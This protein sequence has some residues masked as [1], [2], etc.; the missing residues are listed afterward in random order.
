MNWLFPEFLAGAFA[1]G[2]P[3]LLHLL[4]RWPRRPVVFPSLRFLNAGKRSSD[5]LW[6]RLCRWL[7]L[8]LR[9]LVL[10]LLAA[11]FARPFF[12][13]RDLTRPN[14]AVAI[15]VDNSFSL[16]SG[17]RW[18]DLRQWAR[19]KV[20][21]LAEGDKVGLMLMAPQP[22]WVI[23]PTVDTT[24]PLEALAGLSP[25]WLTARAEPA[26]R[27]A[28]DALAALP[29]D[30]REI[31]LV[32]DEQRLTWSGSDFGRKLPPGVTV[33]SS[34]IPPAPARQAAVLPPILTTTERGLRATVTVRN[35]TGRQTRTLSLYRNDPAIS[36]G[37]ATSRSR[38]GDQEVAAPFSPSAN[39]SPSPRPLRVEKLELEPQETRTVEI[40]LPGPTDHAFWLRCRLDADDLA[41]D[42]SA[43]AVWQPSSEGP[44]LLDAAAPGADADFAGVALASAA[45]LPPAFT[46]MAPPAGKW[47]ARA[48]AVLRND[49]SFSGAAAANLDAFLADGGSALIFASGGPA[50]SAW[51]AVHQVTFSPLPRRTESWPVHDWAMGHALVAALSQR[52]LQMLLGWEFTQGWSMPAQ[53]VEPL[54]HWSDDAAAIGEIRV[55]P[56]RVLACGFIPDRRAGDWPVTPSFLPF[57]HQA[58]TYLFHAQQVTAVTG[59]T[60]QT[61]PLEGPAGRWHG[62][63]GPAA[64]VTETELSGA[65]TPLL[66]G[67]YEFTQDKDRKLFAVN[68]PA[69]E[70]DLASWTA[71]T[72]WLGLISAEPAPEAKIPRVQIA[73]TEAE[74]RAPLWWWA[75]AAAA[76][77]VLAELSLA[78][79]TVR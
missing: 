34:P 44:V 59:L 58:V 56:G 10:A 7:V 35:F 55:G 43:Y 19:E 61:L 40:D 15:V 11:A 46:L 54:A 75:V 12:E 14:R 30:R 67:I 31:I 21:D 41:A 70:S 68:V 79:R 77:L 33:T 64:G 25:G 2:L 29:A 16:Q 78:N 24:R 23:A 13:N 22:S 36:T 45:N 37:D 72:P 28:G 5:N 62:V 1:V 69:E 39:P 38:D 73:A 52:R 76:L 42:D 57:L 51:L 74:Q 6:Q 20:G 18:D 60:G 49:G 50:Q 17:R 63:E 3:L 47:P 71:G 26:L 53:A 27:M 48:V 65:V 8:L 4:R 32:S 66:P 9:C